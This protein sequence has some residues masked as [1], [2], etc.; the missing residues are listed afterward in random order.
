MYRDYGTT[1]YIVDPVH[2]WLLAFRFHMESEGTVRHEPEVKR[3]E[4]ARGCGDLED[5]SWDVDVV[6]NK[7]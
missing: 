7:K 6:C 5:H 4:V 1:T 3:Q 2:I